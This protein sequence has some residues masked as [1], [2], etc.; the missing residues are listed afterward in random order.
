MFHPLTR[1]SPAALDYPSGLIFFIPNKKNV[2][3]LA[4]AFR[5]SG[6]KLFSCYQRLKWVVEGSLSPSLDS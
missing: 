6:G 2:F 5:N 1:P 4:T 3:L